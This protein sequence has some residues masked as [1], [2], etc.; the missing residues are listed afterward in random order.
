M[1]LPTAWG[2]GPAPPLLLLLTCHAWL[3]ASG[4]AVHSPNNNEPAHLGARLH[5]WRTGD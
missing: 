2:G 5:Y 4:D 3:L 1:K